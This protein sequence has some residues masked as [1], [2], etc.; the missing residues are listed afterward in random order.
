M[1][2]RSIPHPLS[3]KQLSSLDVKA[4]F[5]SDSVVNHYTEAAINIGLWRSEESVL[6]R[7]FQPEQTLLE[8]GCGAGRIAFGLW[9]LGFHRL[10]GTD[11]S[12][13]MIT[14]ARRLAA[15]LDYAVPLRV[16]D[17]TALAFEDEMFDGAIFGF[18]GLM[19]IPGRELRRQALREMLRVVRP[20]GRA[21]IT[22]H[23]RS[24]GAPE[25]FWAEEE[26]RW[27][28]GAQDKRLVELG[29]RLM[30]SDHGEIFIHIPTRDEVMADLE[31]AGWRL[32]EDAM[33]STIQTEPAD[34]ESFAVDCRFWVVEK[35]AVS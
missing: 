30:T 19:Q 20:G 15:K 25:G 11:L 32:L 33:R 23:D 6:Q 5:N 2:W 17:A 12:R 9:E 31:A 7:V 24:V 28:A 18:N 4:L 27:L 1:G 10:I 22:T 3:V 35:P 29:D 16:A 8:L 26:A 34:V 21:V 14:A 13:E